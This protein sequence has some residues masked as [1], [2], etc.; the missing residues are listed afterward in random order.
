M[1]V[2]FA[3]SWRFLLS[4]GLTASLLPFTLQGASAQ[5]LPAPPQ[6]AVKPEDGI[7]IEARGPVHEAYA[8]PFDKNVTPP[9][10]VA[11]KPPAP[12][13]EEPPDQKPAA[14]SEWLPGYWSWDSGRNDFIWVSGFWRTP[15]PGKKWMPGHWAQ[16]DNGWQWVSGVWI[17]ADQNLQY[18]P[19]PPPSVDNGPSVPAPNDNSMYIPGAWQ[20]RNDNY[21]WRPGFWN[22]AY[23]DW[24]WTPS[25]YSW[26]P[27]GCAYVP[28]YWDYPL[29]NRGV[30]FAPVY[31]NRPLWQNAGWFY[32]PSWTVDVGELFYSSLFI[33]PYHRNYFFGDYF[34]PSYARAGYWPW[35]AWGRNFHDPLFSYYRWANRGDARWYAGL[36]NSY[37]GRRNGDLARPAT[38]AT[39]RT[40]HGAGL[41]RPF[42]RNAAAARMSA[43]QMR[44][45][46][47]GIQHFQNL[48]N[49]RNR[50]EVPGRRPPV[51]NQVRPA[52]NNGI[53]QAG[54]SGL[55]ITNGGSASHFRE[56]PIV[57]Q[58]GQRSY[59]PAYRNAAP[60]YRGSSHAMPSRS[61]ASFHGGG[62]GHGGGGHGGRH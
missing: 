61:A 31:F 56:Q 44:Q 50:V 3:K 12:V 52:G 36:R 51:A 54:Y 24:V 29:A 39:L 19:E 8:Q 13:P 11:K 22:Q 17:G 32:R 23:S 7:E 10:V 62:G 58:G 47:A 40:D 37:W 27:N 33:G 6:N 53:R 49:Q 16:A 55:T 26:T 43:P 42:D 41:V 59:A 21:V 48:S 14:N 30:L 38:F 35:Y 9:P 4:F 1:P 5:A 25:Y 28:G 34:A 46:Q 18:V 57:H 15:P 45:Q 20:M 60:A 2:Q